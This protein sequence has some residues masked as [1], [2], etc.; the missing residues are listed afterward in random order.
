MNRV[1]SRGDYRYF[2]NVAR[3]QELRRMRRR[4]EELESGEAFVRERK[5]SGRWKARYERQTETV[6]KVE[7]RAE[8]E[9]RKSVKIWQDVNDDLWAE[10]EKLRRQ[11]EKSE[12]GR[13]EVCERCE[14]LEKK[15]AELYEANRALFYRLNRNHTNSH[16]PS[17][18]DRPGASTK[19]HDNNSRTKS[20]KS[21]GGQPG[22]PHHPRKKLNPTAPPQIHTTPPAEI[23]GSPDWFLTD[24]YLEHDEVNIRMVVE[25]IPHRAMIWK[26]D[27]TGETKAS[28][29]PEGLH[30]E[31]NYSKQTE[32]VVLMLTH[33]ANV[34]NRKV[35]QM[36]NELTDRRSS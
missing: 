10:I 9:R 11:Y 12:A 23:A 24:R 27:L 21:R 18:G 3:D 25:A 5:R 7:A 13:K 2:D 29:F 36:L 16:V 34:A 1:L 31:T 33:A 30:G 26:N 32:A 20:G 28:V 15:C 4:V 17:S 19:R 8:R 22:H 6:K 14:E 35:K